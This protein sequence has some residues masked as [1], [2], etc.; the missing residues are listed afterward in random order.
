MYCRGAKD[1]ELPDEVRD[2]LMRLRLGCRD[3]EHTFQRRQRRKEE[4]KMR[5]TLLKIKKEKKD[6]RLGGV[7]EL[8]IPTYA[9]GV[10]DEVK[11]DMRRKTGL[12]VS[13]G[14][15]VLYL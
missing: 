10:L 9:K 1:A 3:R 5:E 11:E 8:W 14:D 13:N 4:E 12:P 2:L 6:N 7:R 15:A